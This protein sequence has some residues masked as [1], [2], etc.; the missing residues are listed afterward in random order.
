MRR[1]AAATLA[2]LCGL[3]CAADVP[4]GG[5]TAA[6]VDGEV[7]VGDPAVVALVPRRVGCEDPAPTPLCTGF[8][9]STRV[10]VTA[11]HCVETEDPSG[12]EIFVGDEVGG[13]GRYYAVE[14][15][16]RHPDFDPDLLAWDVSVMR[17][18][19]D[20][21]ETPAALANASLTD[22]LVGTTVR[23]VGFGATGPGEI[24]DGIKREGTMMV[25][26]L[27]AEHVETAAAPA[28]TCLGDSGGPLFAELDGTERVI[29]INSHGDFGCSG[30][31]SA[32]RLDAVLDSF[33][34]P[35]VEEA[36]GRTLRGAGGA[37]EAAALCTDDCTDDSD[38]PFALPCTEGRCTFGTIGP[39][40]FGGSCTRS[41]DCG[42][43]PLCAR[44]ADDACNCWQ[45]CASDEEV[46]PDDSGCGIVVGRAPAPSFLWLL[47]LALVLRRRR[48]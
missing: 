18:A 25:T 22:A 36:D 6:I 21:A 5:A 24:V 16:R 15:V 38:C 26:A 19:Q 40:S 46:P 34:R 32:L 43:A 41:E 8:L 44:T 23:S 45:A 9:A 28:M 2:G 39:G 13:A 3:G 48:R 17:L 30:T 1:L 20:V 7:R 29:G 31:G 12:Y 27:D 11:G 33:V 10:V 37:L 35:Y 42:E 47:P 4:T 14:D